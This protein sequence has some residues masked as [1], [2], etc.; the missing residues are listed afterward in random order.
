MTKRAHLKFAGLQ[1]RTIAAYRI[2]LERFLAF[3]VKHRTNLRSIPHLDDTLTEYFNCMRQEGE[4]VSAAGHT[5]SGIK[6]FIPEL[7]LQLPISSQFFRSW[8]RCRRPLR[9]VPFSWEMPQAMAAIAWRQGSPATALML[10]IGFNCF[11]RTA[12]ML[13]LQLCHLLPHRSKSEVAVIIPCSKTSNGNLQVLLGKDYNIRRLA[14]RLKADKPN[15]AFLWAGQAT[16]FRRVWCR[17]LVRLDFREDDDSPYG[18][19]R[20]GAAWLFLETSSLDATLAHGRWAI[21]KVARQ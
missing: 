10:Y 13:A 12:E 20:G 14:R 18:V 17:I 8:Q 21:A 2:A 9:A 4:P 19:R 11:L 7:K 5:L 3:A 16:S 6:R 1:R 15:T